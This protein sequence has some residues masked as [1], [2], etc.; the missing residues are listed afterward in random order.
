MPQSEVDLA[1]LFN[2]VT[3]AL[4]GEQASLNEADSYNHDHGDNMVQN[5][6]VITKAIKQKADASPSEQLAHASDALRKASS[7]GSANLYS[8]GLAQAADQLRGQPAITSQNAM[9]LVNALIGGQAPALPAKG[10]ASDV[11]G[12]LL[13]SLMGGGESTGAT[14]QPSGNP[15]GDTL[16]GLL[17]SLLGGGSSQSG[18]D[19]QGGGLD[20]GSLLSAG[21]SLLGGQGGS[22]LGGLV[23][24]LVGNSQMN[25]SAHHTQS[26]QLVVSTLIG[27]LGKMLGGSK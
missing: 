9:G 23:G 25:T 19:G 6:K 12:G 13:S 11:I 18:S 20:L 15:A 17:G 5:F 16:S 24:A 21:A 27:A 26:G 8:Q 7:T 2:S 4:K 22:G 14:A 10:G 1:S 3:K